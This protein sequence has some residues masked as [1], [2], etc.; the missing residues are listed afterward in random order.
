MEDQLEYNLPDTDI[1]RS[2]LLVKKEKSTPKKYPR[3]A[4]TPAKEPLL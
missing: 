4:G 3:K 2:L 1:K